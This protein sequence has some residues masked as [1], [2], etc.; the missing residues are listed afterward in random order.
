MEA[1]P[2]PTKPAL[3]IGWICIFAGML[4][5][6]LVLMTAARAMIFAFPICC[7]ILVLG[8]FLVAGRFP[9]QRKT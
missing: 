8:L 7:I 3:I 4:L 1:V 5:P 9:P 2:N 6:I